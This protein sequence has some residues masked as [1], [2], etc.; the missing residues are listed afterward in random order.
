ME[1][2][3]IRHDLKGEVLDFMRSP[4]AYPATSYFGWNPPVEPPPVGGCEEVLSGEMVSVYR[5]MS[6]SLIHC[7]Y[8]DRVGLHL[9]C[10]FADIF[11]W[12]PN[13][14]PYKGPHELDW[15]TYIDQCYL[16]THIVFTTNNWGELSLDPAMFPHEY[17]FLRS[18]LEIHLQQRD[19]HLIAEFVETLR[20]FGCSDNDILIQRGMRALLSMQQESGIWDPSD[21]P[22]RTY[23]ATMCGAQALLAHKYRG[24][25][26]GIPDVLPLLIQWTKDDLNKMDLYKT[27]L[28]DQPSV[29]SQKNNHSKQWEFRVSVDRPRDRASEDLV[30][31]LRTHMRGAL[32]NASSS[33]STTTTTTTTKKPASAPSSTAITAAAAAVKVVTESQSAKDKPKSK[34]D[35]KP[36]LELTVKAKLQ[37]FD[38]VLRKYLSSGGVGQ[39]DA[40]LQQKIISSLLEAKDLKVTHEL[41]KGVPSAGRGVKTLSKDKGKGEA[42]DDIVAATAALV[43]SAWKERVGITPITPAVAVTPLPSTTATETTDDTSPATGTITTATYSTDTAPSSSPTPLPPS[44]SASMAVVEREEE[45]FTGIV[46]EETDGSSVS[47][48]DVMMTTDSDSTTTM[49]EVDNIQTAVTVAEA[50]A[51]VAVEVVEAEGVG[52]VD[53]ETTDSTAAVEHTIVTED[54]S[55]GSSCDYVVD[56]EDPVVDNNCSSEME[57]AT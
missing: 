54:N 20:A 52:D 35:K 57:V 34:T 11:R 38:D 30:D 42:M 5:T 24:F 2:V 16:I 56:E 40:A 15:Q 39:R 27:M 9:G 3:G 44:D 51:V 22:Y 41:L 7:F 14:R 28:S 25:G 10:T 1:R 18:N 32:K 26:P 13:L 43:L 49:E 12:L 19:I 6:N 29:N 4:N 36:P 47:A 8:A 17:F 33:S 48:T 50:E 46:A 53:T 55:S 45:M 31:Q 37:N 23:H 21:E